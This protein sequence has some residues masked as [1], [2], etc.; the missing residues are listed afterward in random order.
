MKTKILLS[1]MIIMV[2]NPLPGSAQKNNKKIQISG[3][4]KDI[5]GNP[6]MGAGII[7]DNLS[8]DRT[9][10]KKGFYKVR[11]K[12]GAKTIC[13]FILGKS[14]E[15][16]TIDGRSEINFSLPTE[17][18]QDITKNVGA[19]EDEPVNIG[20]GYAKR[21]NSSNGVSSVDLKKGNAT[22]YT[23]IYQ[24]I[25]GKVPGV[26]VNGTKIT[27]RGVSSINSGTDPL[28]VVDGMVVNSID[29][30]NP[31][32]VKAIDVLKGSSAAIYGSRGANGVILITLKGSNR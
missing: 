9:T 4:V 20:Y 13:I 17:V 6:V 27:I 1:L 3:Y 18:I 24:M 11:V 32:E 23:D 5:K 26:T 29:F 12:P 16:S 30:I 25:S 7:I 19:D 2:I 14:I 8:T 21:N 15:E 31:M 28:L 10:D 22:M